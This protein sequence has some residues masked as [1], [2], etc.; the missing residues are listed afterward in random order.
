MKYIYPI[1]LFYTSIL[2]Y[3]YPEEILFEFLIIKV[4]ILDVLTTLTRFKFK[5][6]TP[7]FYIFSFKKIIKY[8]QS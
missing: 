6:L 8:V 2:F 4:R 7:P 1:Y 3:L 5:A